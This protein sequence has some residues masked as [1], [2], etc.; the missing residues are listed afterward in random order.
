[1]SSII[2]TKNANRSEDEHHLEAATKTDE[3]IVVQDVCKRFGRNEPTIIKLSFTVE[4]GQIFCLLGPSGSGKST[5]MRMLTGVL[6][7][8]E[9]YMHVLGVAP[10]NFTRKTRS[11][12]GYMPQHFVL[13]PELSTLDNINFVASAYGMSWFGRAKRVREVLEFVDLW[14]ARDRLVSQLSGGMRRRLDLASTLVHRPELIFAD[15]P[16]AGIDPILRAKFWDHFK[17]IRDE[18]RTIFVTTQ[19]V[20]EA[21]YCDR[22]AILS[23]GRLLA[24]GTPEEVRRRAMGGDIINLKMEDVTSDVLR[25]LRQIPGMLDIFTVSPQEVRLTVENSSEILKELIALFHQNNLE[26][27]NIEPYRPDFEE[28]FVR[29]MEQDIKAGKSPV[30]EPEEPPALPEAKRVAS[31]ISKNVKE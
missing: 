26:I 31:R 9:G 21:D 1:M 10:E 30:L 5:T 3:V 22:V 19:Y 29:L 11:R 15:E 17:S 27:Y 4:K 12:I 28:V 23:Q 7:P 2:E 16:T 13:F 6:E 18:G 20:T 25:L 8:S 14:D 24:L